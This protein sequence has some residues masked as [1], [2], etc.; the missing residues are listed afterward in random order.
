MA[1]QHDTV[2]AYLQQGID[3]IKAKDKNL[4]R[5]LLAQASELDPNNVAVWFW[6]SAA[7]EDPYEQEQCLLKVIALDPNNTLAAKGLGIAQ[8]RIIDNAFERGVTAV[9]ENNPEFAR[10]YFTEVIER[11]QG[12]L[13]AWE[14]LSQV[15]ETSEDQEV[16]FTN[17]LFLDPENDVIRKK[18]TLLKQTREMAEH[19]P[20]IEDDTEEAQDSQFIAPTLAGDILGKAYVEKYTTVIPEPDE[21]T[22]LPSVALWA[23]YNDTLGCPYCGHS[24]EYK[25]R[26][27]PECKKPLWVSSHSTESRSTML[28][29]V[30]MLQALTTIILAVIPLVILFIVAQRLGIFN[31]FNLIPAYLGR[32]SP[33]NPNIIKAAYVILPRGWFFLSWVPALVTLIFAIALY[34]QWTPVYYLM[35]VGAGLGLTGSIAG[36]A[37]IPAFEGSLFA[38]ALGILLSLSTLVMVIK[39]ES[40]FRKIRR[41]YFLDIDPD[42]QDGMAFLIRGKQYARK[43]MWALSAIHLR[44]ANALM[45]FDA[46]GYLATAVA[47]SQLHDYELAR[48]VLEEA[49]RMDPENTRIQEALEVLS[50]AQT[51]AETGEESTTPGQEEDTEETEALDE[52][53]M[54]PDL[55]DEVGNSKDLIITDQT[56]NQP[57]SSDPSP[58]PAEDDDPGS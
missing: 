2:K 38:G 27:C 3:A 44:R 1:E 53:D 12:N 34:L 52:F 40:D 30:I 58:E 11:D 19:N 36:L 23:R 49:Q 46:G 20:W 28:W 4:A 47:C 29:F 39:L 18:L 21:E 31:F 51:R 9:Q 13:A 33:L 43:G 48:T 5:D 57:I 55:D 16:C 22:E 45:P 10:G 17:I 24:T 7:L 41:R 8:Q 37:M 54:P 50:T 56:L 35:L 14:W 6:L 32:P 42:L 26:R 15:V 25:Q